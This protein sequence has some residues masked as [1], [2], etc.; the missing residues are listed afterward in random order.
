[1][2]FVSEGES[3]VIGLLWV[4]VVTQGDIFRETNRI[5]VNFFKLICLREHI[6]VS[7]VS[8]REIKP[9]KDGSED[10]KDLCVNL[11]SK[12]LVTGFRFDSPLFSHLIDKLLKCHGTGTRLHLFLFAHKFLLCTLFDALHFFWRNL[13]VSYLMKE[14][15]IVLLSAHFWATILGSGHRFLFLLFLRAI[16][17]AIANVKFSPSHCLLE[18]V[19]LV[20]ELT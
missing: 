10:F 11:V 5:L 20:N 9:G 4:P 15:I 17:L 14:I 2:Q 3:P 13:S 8:P 18:V 7:K 6:F 16:C 19:L 1:V 12:L